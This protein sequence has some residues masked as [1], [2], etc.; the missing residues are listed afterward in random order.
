MA[1]IDLLLVNSIYSVAVEVKT[2]LTIGNVNDH[3]KRLERLQANP[4]RTIKGT[5]LLGAVAGMNIKQEAEEHAIQN[6]L[7]VLKQKGEIMEVANNK[8]FRPHEWVVK[9]S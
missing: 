2:T 3:I 6:G 5:K 4:I 1:E 9:D 7:F 8:E